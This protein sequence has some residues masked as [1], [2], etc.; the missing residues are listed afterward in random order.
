[1]IDS[2]K[3]FLFFFNTFRL[4]RNAVIM[5][6]SFEPDENW[7]YLC[8]GTLINSDTVVTGEQF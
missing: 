3:E 7:K 6:R 4:I 2:T 5:E 8:G 1:M